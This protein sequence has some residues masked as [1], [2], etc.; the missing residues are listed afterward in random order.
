MESLEIENVKVEEADLRMVAS[1]GLIIRSQL[2][3]LLALRENLREMFEEDLIYH[4][5]SSL[6]L[7]LVHWN[8]LNEESQERIKGRRRNV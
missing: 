7:Y 2:G 1:C 6:P 3:S 4:T 8:D 5:N